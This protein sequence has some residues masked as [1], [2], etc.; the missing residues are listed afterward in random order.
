MSFQQY[1]QGPPTLTGGLLESETELCELDAKFVTA[2]LVS[3]M[4]GFL[5]LSLHW[6]FFVFSFHRGSFHKVGLLLCLASASR[7]AKLRL[8]QLG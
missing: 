6:V 2:V 1:E 3:G 4:L 5:S 7:G 8:F